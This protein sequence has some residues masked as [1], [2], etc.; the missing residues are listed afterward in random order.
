MRCVF[1]TAQLVVDGMT[2]GGLEPHA[3]G[4]RTA[5]KVRLMHAAT[6]YMFRHDPEDQWDA[7]ALGQPIN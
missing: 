6:R 2:E 7:H 3:Q 5:Q 1:E 4:V